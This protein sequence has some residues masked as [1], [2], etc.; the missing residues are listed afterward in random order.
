[1]FRIAAIN[2]TNVGYKGQPQ[3]LIDLVRSSAG[4][5]AIKSTGMEP[6]DQ[7]PPAK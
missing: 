7:N 3:A 2:L 6:I 1:M 5:V 4:A